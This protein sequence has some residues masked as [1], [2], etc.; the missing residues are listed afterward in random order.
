MIDL[1]L[2]SL[3]LFYIS[4]LVIGFKIQKKNK[5]KLNKKYQKYKTFLLI[6]ITS[7]M[8]LS[9]SI[10]LQ[11]Y[12]IYDKTLPLLILNVLFFL[13]FF[14]GVFHNTRCWKQHRMIIYNFLLIPSI[15]FSSL[16]LN[17][18]IILSIFILIYVYNVL[19]FQFAKFNIRES[20]IWD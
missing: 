15:Y 4:T 10:F 20:L 6:I 17:N 5:D 9:T 19:E 1:T 7:I 3:F 11:A 14:S 16:V 12:Y 13:Y 2:F 8:L 18:E